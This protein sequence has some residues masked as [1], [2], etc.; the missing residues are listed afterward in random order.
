MA[1]VATIT[2]N[3]DLTTGWLQEHALKY[4]VAA[5]APSA[6]ETEPACG[7]IHCDLN[8]F[9][10]YAILVRAACGFNLQRSTAASTSD[11]QL[12]R[13][14]HPYYGMLLTEEVANNLYRA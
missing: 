1:C 14:S 11:T 5:V 13:H 10:E 3:T 4:I 9:E 8:G 2:E 7:F 6:F 12:K